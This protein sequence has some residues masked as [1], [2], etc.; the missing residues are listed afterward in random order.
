MDTARF[1]KGF[2]WGVV[3]TIAM[4]VV[5]IA[6]VLT[7]LSPMPKPI[8]VAIVGTILGG[9]LPHPALMALGAAAHLLYGGTFGGVL[10]MVTY[11]LTVWK[12]VLLGV[13]LWLLMQ[14][15]WL[16]FLGWGM[17]GVAV[18]PIIAGATLVLH[19][20]Y[21]ATVGWLIDRH[22]YRASHAVHV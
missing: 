3:A 2:G 15:F 10:A 9:G 18:T 5:M 20:I 6:G 17:F 14:V 13:I 8:P 16:P 7:G 1:R 4:S 19:V 22:A 21:G 11:P 12:G